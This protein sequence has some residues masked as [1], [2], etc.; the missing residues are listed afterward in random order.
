MVFDIAISEENILVKNQEISQKRLISPV[1][2]NV[3]VLIFH[4]FTTQENFRLQY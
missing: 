2:V 1:K 4:L 3:A